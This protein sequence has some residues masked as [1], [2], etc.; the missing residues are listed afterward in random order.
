MTFNLHGFKINLI[1]PMG[2]FDAF[3]KAM[4]KSQTP[5]SLRS[6][7]QG[8]LYLDLKDFEI[9]RPFECNRAQLLMD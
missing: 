1:N 9:K 8:P 6:I 4:F 5:W 3:N 7:M 2:D